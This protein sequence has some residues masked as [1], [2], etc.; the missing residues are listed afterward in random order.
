MD[1]YNSDAYNTIVAL[2][3]SEGSWNVESLLKL[4]EGTQPQISPG[5]LLA[6]E[7]IVK[8]DAR[9]QALAKD[10]GELVLARPT[11]IL[12][13]HSCDIQALSRTRSSLMDGRLGTMTVSHCHCACNKHSY[14]RVSRNMTTSM[15]ILWY[16]PSLTRISR[17]IQQRKQDFI[18]VVDI[19][20]GKV[21]H[22]DF[23]GTY[24]S[25]LA[26]T[27]PP[28]LDKDS[29]ERSLPSRVPPPRTPQDFL[30]DLIEDAAKKEGKEWKQREAPKPL[31]VVQPEGVSFKMD[32]HI[33]EWQKWKMH[34]G[35]P[36]LRLDN[37]HLLS[38]GS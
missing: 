9:V 3:N 20:A 23:L 12:G 30:P 36:A 25:A 27:R 28:P 5:E 1:L 21:V 10:V 2:D 31:H 6:C 34:I 38:Y 35:R 7:D 14:S 26:S 17:S 33:L 22:I 37:L 29:A 13:T 32:G 16:S 24:P 11:I 8:N 4:P 18:P 15:H 19:V